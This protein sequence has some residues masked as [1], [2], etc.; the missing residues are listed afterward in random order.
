MHMPR[1]GTEVTSIRRRFPT[2]TIPTRPATRAVPVMR[3][4]S[5]CHLET[6]GDIADFQRVAPALPLFENGFSAFARG[7]LLATEFGPCAVEDLLPGTR[8]QTGDG[9][10]EPLLWKGNMSVIPNAP[11]PQS[12]HQ[13]LTRFSADGF[14][15]NGP[16]PDLMLGPG[17]RVVQRNTHIAALAGTDS[18]SVPAQ[19]LV[20][21][22]AVIRVKPVT[23]VEVYHLMFEHHTTVRVNGLEC[24][25]F[26]PGDHAVTSLSYEMAPHFLSLFP[27]IDKFDDFGPQTIARLT[28]EE[29]ANLTAA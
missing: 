25:S 6:N 19:C 7:S 27:H 10:F 23:S 15:L 21:G 20:D 11:T 29:T 13:H 9:S 26:H 24:E 1:S 18:V 2:P 14:G 16:G 28:S 3:R 5:V 8:V 22:D 4:Y 17:A 12:A